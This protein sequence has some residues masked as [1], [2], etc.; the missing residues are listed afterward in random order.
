MKALIPVVLIFFTNVA[1]AEQGACFGKMKYQYLDQGVELFTSVSV[2]DKPK[3]PF[4][5]YEDWG[6]SYAV[7]FP[8]KIEGHDFLWANVF[9]GK[10]RGKPL[11]ETRLYT[12]GN[13]VLTGK[14]STILEDQVFYI[15]VEYMVDCSQIILEQRF[16]P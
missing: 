12:Y 11:F 3:E 9:F 13:E 2:W 15:R 14:F 5:N 1:F 10:D 8:S 16:E 7:S 6:T 4:E